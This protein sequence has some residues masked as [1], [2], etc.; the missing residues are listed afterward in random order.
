MRT[1]RFPLGFALTLLTG[2]SVGIAVARTPVEVFLCA[3]L[4]TISAFYIFFT[5]IIP[6]L[7]P[8]TVDTEGIFLGGVAKS[9]YVSPSE[10]FAPG[11]PLISEDLDKTWEL[12]YDRNKL[13]PKP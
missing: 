10:L 9:P 12:Y 5:I 2:G 13:R 4:V 11:I 3:E 1:R 7:R 8:T 6:A